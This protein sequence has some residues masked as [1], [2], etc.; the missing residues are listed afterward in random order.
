[1]LIRHLGLPK[2]GKFPYSHSSF[3]ISPVFQR[4]WDGVEKESASPDHDL[5]IDQLRFVGAPS[6]DKMAFLNKNYPE[7]AKFV[8]WLC[9]RHAVETKGDLAQTVLMV[10][11]PFGEILSKAMDFS[12][13]TRIS[14]EKLL[15][16]EFSTQL[17]DA[18]QHGT[19]RKPIR[20]EFDDLGFFLDTKDLRY[21]ILY[22]IN[23]FMPLDFFPAIKKYVESLLATKPSKQMG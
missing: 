20:L 18:P 1:M 7:K 12:P 5:L 13:E 21:L 3:P 6:Q 22:E 17:S 10:P 9:G 19:S 14:S 4:R 16:E 8:E 11:R 15:E 2:L 23:E